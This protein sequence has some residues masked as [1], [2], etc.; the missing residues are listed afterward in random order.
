MNS[1]HFVT[2]LQRSHVTSYSQV[3]SVCYLLF[4]GQRFGHL[5]CPHPIRQDKK[6]HSSRNFNWAGRIVLFSG[7]HATWKSSSVWASFVVLGGPSVRNRFQSDLNISLTVIKK[8][9]CQKELGK[10]K[11][12]FRDFSDIA[13]AFTSP[14]TPDP[15][16]YTNTFSLPSIHVWINALVITGNLPAFSICSHQ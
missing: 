11:K 12:L 6:S 2:L 16:T 9:L 5:S 7:V 8:Y 3:S 1:S 15:N 10:E 4:I 14:L 13:L